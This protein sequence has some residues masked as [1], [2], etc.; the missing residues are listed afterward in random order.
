MDMTYTKYKRAYWAH[1][2]ATCRCPVADAAA[3]AAWLAK[4]HAAR[5]L[6]SPKC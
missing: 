3:V 1:K 5:L 2:A 4:Y 6:Q